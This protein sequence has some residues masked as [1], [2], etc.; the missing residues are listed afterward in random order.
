MS[1]RASNK[2]EG[3]QERLDAHIA[4]GRIEKAQPLITQC[5]KPGP[6]IIDASNLKALQKMQVRAAIAK[7]GF[8][9]NAEQDDDYVE[10]LKTLNPDYCPPKKKEIESFC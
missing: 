8:A 10:F 9:V 4:L 1:K 2:A 3:F 5:D 7:G 6:L